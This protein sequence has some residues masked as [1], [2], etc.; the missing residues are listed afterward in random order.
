MLLP[1]ILSA[2]RPRCAPCRGDVRLCLGADVDGGRAVVVR[3]LSAEVPVD[4][5]VANILQALRASDSPT[6]NAGLA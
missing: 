4:G 3:E 1:I 6:T 2:A 5:I